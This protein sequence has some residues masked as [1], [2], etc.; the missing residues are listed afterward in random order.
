MRSIIF[1]FFLLFCSI[2]ASPQYSY[3]ICDAACSDF[4]TLINIFLQTP[5][6]KSINEEIYNR[7]DRFQD[8]I[9][10][11]HVAQEERYKLNSLIADVVIV[12]LFI[13]PISNKCNSHLSGKQL[14]RLQTIFGK[15]FMKAKLNVKCPIDEIEFIEISLGGLKV[16]YFHNISKKTGNGLRIKYYAASGS[17]TSRGEYGS[18]ENEYVP[19]LHN[20]GTKYLRMISATIIERF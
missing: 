1:P 19:V 15:D 7:L 11:A 14:D 3:N 4:K 18:M 6:D 5:T 20:V 13:A 9:G 17:T 16:C 10:K 12:K 8:E 2:E